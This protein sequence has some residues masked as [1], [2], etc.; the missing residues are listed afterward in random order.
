MKCRGDGAPPL[1]IYSSLV[2]RLPTP[3]SL[4]LSHTHTHTHTLTHNS[5]NSRIYVQARTQAR[6]QTRA[7]PAQ[8]VTTTQNAAP[9]QHPHATKFPLTTII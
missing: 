6:A 5:H 3:P 9:I 7:H 2:L 8:R 4:S 1:C